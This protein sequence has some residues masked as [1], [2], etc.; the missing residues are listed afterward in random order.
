MAKR[1]ADVAAVLTEEQRTK[2]TQLREDAK[3]RRAASRKA[4]S[5]PAGGNP[6][7]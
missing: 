2:V 4:A 7:P 6:A 1:D 5:E 3:A